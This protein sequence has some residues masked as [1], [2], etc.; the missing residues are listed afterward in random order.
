MSDYS[1]FTKHLRGRYGH[2]AR[3]DVPYE[4]RDKG[5]H[6]CDYGYGKSLLR[7]RLEKSDLVLAHRTDGIDGDYQGFGWLLGRYSRSGTAYVQIVPRIGEYGLRGD[8]ISTAV[9]I[10]SELDLVGQRT[11]SSVSEAESALVTQRRAAKLARFEDETGMS[12]EWFC[13]YVDRRRKEMEPLNDLWCEI[14]AAELA[15]PARGVK[16]RGSDIADTHSELSDL[17]HLTR[18]NWIRRTAEE[19]AIPPHPPSKELVERVKLDMDGR[20]RENERWQAER[21]RLQNEHIAK[22]EQ[23]NQEVEEFGR[24]AKMSALFFVR[25]VEGRRENWATFGQI[26]RELKDPARE[27]DF[28][29][30]SLETTFEEIKQKLNESDRYWRNETAKRPE[31]PPRETKAP[32]HPVGIPFIRL[33]TWSPAAT[34]A[35][36]SRITNHVVSRSGKIVPR[37]QTDCEKDTSP[38]PRGP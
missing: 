7:K 14:I 38:A 26:A 1:D 17:L 16:L 10:L 19:P 8:E 28:D 12:P 5:F 22:V 11:F 32:E 36:A 3:W 6:K 9:S 18:P 15:N 34:S 29:A 30:A 35:I 25:Y 23:L 21:E 24:K 13:Q 20:K 33:K 37:R 2:D 4:L 27:I 31:I